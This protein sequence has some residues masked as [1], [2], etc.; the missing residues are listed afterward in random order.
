MSYLKSLLT[1]QHFNFENS[2]Y[3]VTK[4]ETGILH[5]QPKEEAKSK[6]LLSC[7][8][9][10]NE[11]APIEIVDDILNDLVIGKQNNSCELMLIFGSI[12]GMKKA[13]RYL[14]FNLNRL[15]S[16]VWKTHPDAQEAKRA[17]VIEKHVANFFKVKLD[18][19]LHLDLHTALFPSHHLR[20]AIVPKKEK[21]YEGELSSLS[22]LG[23]D[24]LC[25]GSSEAGTFSFYTQTLIGEKGHSA[26]I[27]LGK[28]MPF[29]Q[30]NRDD[31]S[32]AEKSLRHLVENG[33]L[34]QKETATTYHISRE[35]RRDHEDYVLHLADDF[36]NF[37]LLDP[38]EPLEETL[39]GTT[40]A[41]TNE[42]LIFPN[43]K[44]KIGQRSGLILNKVI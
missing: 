17:E 8:I 15:F 29:G 36:K 27:E 11:T 39:E 7:G 18:Y 19:N 10:G 35:L 37:T 28:V 23:L 34:P 43:G 32:I 44:V 6:V 31:F 4:L 40:Y 42:Y 2:H 12:P 22:S 14:D 13:R 21:A 24:A 26:T 16:E 41:N 5:I 38:K 33:K 1:D 3:R 25:V 20:F 9:H 30:N